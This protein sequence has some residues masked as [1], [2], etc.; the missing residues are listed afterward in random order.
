MKEE[1]TME[2]KDL[3]SGMVVELRNKSLYMV[4][5]GMDIYILMV[6]L[7]VLTEMLGLI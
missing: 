7:L 5:R 3:R 2:L 1:L 4:V 6:L